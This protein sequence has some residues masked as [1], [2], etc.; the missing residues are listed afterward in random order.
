MRKETSDVSHKMGLGE[1]PR[2]LP[3]LAVGPQAPGAAPGGQRNHAPLQGNRCVP[4]CGRVE[5]VLGGK[6]TSGSQVPR[7]RAVAC[8]PA[9]RPGRRLRRW[10][11]PSQTRDTGLPNAED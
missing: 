6:A 9:D 8:G 5:I 2:A 1:T 10:A 3:L 11:A 7:P 4:A